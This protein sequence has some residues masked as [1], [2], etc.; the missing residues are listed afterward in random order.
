MKVLILNGPGLDDLRRLDSSFDKD[1]TLDRIEEAC[2]ALCASYGIDMTFRQGDVVRELFDWVGRNAS[3][4]DALIIN[5]IGYYS[6]EAY[7][8]FEKYRSAIKVLAHLKKPVVEVHISNIF[9][10]G[11]HLIE[12][13]REPDAQ[14]GFICGLGLHSYLL[15]IE[16][17]A[18]KANLKGSTP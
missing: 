3:E 4:F 17:I 14:I 8:T 12:P 13:L 9:R 2:G 15:A 1:L 16:S 5:P 10:R 11:A 7:E 18:Q 6:Y